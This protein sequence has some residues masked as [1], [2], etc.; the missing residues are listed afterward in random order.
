[1]DLWVD[2]DT[3]LPWKITAEGSI[4]VPAGAGTTSGPIEFRMGFEFEEYN[5]DVNIPEAPQDAKSFVE[6]F[7]DGGGLFGDDTGD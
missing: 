1:M 2:A 5:G 4:D 6:L 7:S 3:G